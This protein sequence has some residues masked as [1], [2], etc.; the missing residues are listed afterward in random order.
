MIADSGFFFLAVLFAFVQVG[1]S[2]SFFF[3]RRIRNS[4]NDDEKW[5]LHMPCGLNVR[6]YL[7]FS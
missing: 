5:T 1:P 4:R 7:L 2:S 6:Y 3:E